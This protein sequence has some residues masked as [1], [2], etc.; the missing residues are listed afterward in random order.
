MHFQLGFTGRNHLVLIF[1]FH[2]WTQ[3]NTNKSTVPYSDI[4][5]TLD[6]IDKSKD[7]IDL[8][9]AK[10]LQLRRSYSNFA[11]VS[12]LSGSANTPLEWKTERLEDLLLG[13]TLYDA[14]VARKRQLQELYSVLRDTIDDATWAS[15][16][17]AI[18][19][20]QSDNVLFKYIVNSSMHL[21]QDL[22]ASFH[23]V[24]SIRNLLMS[25]FDCRCEFDDLY[26]SLRA[27]C[28]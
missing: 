17:N 19:I 2:D 8:A 16:L 10:R 4:D 3:N 12:C 5:K 20:Q 22:S 9:V 27:V 24:R 14:T 28:S 7:V 18:E 26:S 11:Y 6:N 21:I 13:T 25:V 1:L 15:L 23:L